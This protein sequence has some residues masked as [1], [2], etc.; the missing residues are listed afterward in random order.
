MKGPSAIFGTIVAV[1]SLV[2]GKWI[3]RPCK[4]YK[5]VLPWSSLVRG[6]WIESVSY[7][8]LRLSNTVFP[9][10]REVD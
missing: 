6:K 5:A 9:R 10:E 3:E 7:T 1:S 4:F 8:S 2:R